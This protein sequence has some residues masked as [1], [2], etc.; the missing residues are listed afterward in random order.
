LPA[1]R[2]AAPAAWAADPVAPITPVSVNHIAIGVS[3]LKRSKDW[4]TRVLKLK[5]VQETETLALLQFGETQLVLRPP[6]LAHPSASVGTISHVMFGVSPY[7]E[8]S[9]ERTLKAQGL[10]PRKDLESFLVR[11]PDNLIVQIGDRKMG[12]DVGYPPSAS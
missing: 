4:Y 1:Q 8:G 12:L 2:A 3:N 11:D 5:L 9:L 7:D 10:E 6:T